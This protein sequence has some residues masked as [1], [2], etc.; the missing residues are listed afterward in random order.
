MNTMIMD[1]Y[2]KPSGR[3]H[4][5]R[6][7]SY[8]MDES[9]PLEWAAS[10]TCGM[11]VVSLATEE[12]A[13][14]HADNHWK[15]NYEAPVREEVLFTSKGDEVVVEWEDAKVADLLMTMQWSDFATS[16]ASSFEQYGKWTPGQRPWA[17]KLAYDHRDREAAKKEA[18]AAPKAPAQDGLF[19]PIVDMLHG[20]QAH[21]KYPKIRIEGP[22]GQPL[23]LSV[24]GDRAKRPGTINVTDGG[25]FGDNQWYGR[26]DLQGNHEGRA[27]EWVIDTLLAF[28]K[29]PA[30]QAKAYGQRYAHCCFCR[31][32]LSTTESL[33]AGYGPVCAER[34]GLP[35][36]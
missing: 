23:Q 2:K 9:S 15:A 5:S 3:K 14:Y 12:E 24:A 26:L 8:R 30:G 31:R 35:W 7:F 28:A 6:A 16:L 36:G 22:D 21:L 4:D 34:Y 10:C 33:D 1:H 25:P 27:P 18:A 32:E 20:A 19:R 17:H 11:N 13:R 29:D